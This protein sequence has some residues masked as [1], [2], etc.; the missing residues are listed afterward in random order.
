MR[1]NQIATTRFLRLLPGTLV[2]L[3]LITTLL[4]CAASKEEIG[5][6]QR[7]HSE[8]RSRMVQLDRNQDRMQ[9]DIDSI[10]TLLGEVVNQELRAM[11]ADQSATSQDFERRLYTLTLRFEENERLLTDLLQR[12]EDVYELLR[13]PI[14]IDGVHASEEENALYEQGQEEY[15]RGEYELARMQYRQLKTAFPDSPLADDALYW[16]GE[17]FMAD[18]QPDSAQTTFILVLQTYPESNRIAATLL[19]LGII[20]LDNENVATARGFFEAILE[21]FPDSPEAEQATL[22][23][24]EM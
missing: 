6:F 21:Q 24:E 10:K 11:Q 5:Q 9:A 4:G 23:L 18:Q 3:M 13:S 8:F 2:G 1:H 7:D 17:S 16:I 20:D 22:R 19:K 14:T 12:L 15:L